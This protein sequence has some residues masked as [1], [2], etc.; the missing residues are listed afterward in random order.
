MI[1]VVIN[2]LSTEP[3]VVISS[4]SLTQS[5]GAVEYTDSTSSTSVLDMILNNQMVRF[6]Y[7]WGFAEYPFIAIAPKFTLTLNGSTW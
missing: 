3:L 7:C 5:A 1:A 6:Q 2:L 4:I